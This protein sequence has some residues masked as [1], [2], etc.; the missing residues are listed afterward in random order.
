MHFLIVLMTGPL[1][2][3]YIDSLAQLMF[4]GTSADVSSHHSEQIDIYYPLHRHKHRLIN[5]G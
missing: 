4:T 1:Q 3:L 5:S 2:A